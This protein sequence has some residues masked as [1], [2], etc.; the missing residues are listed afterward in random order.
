MNSSMNRAMNSTRD[1]T[2]DLPNTL[3]ACTFIVPTL[4]DLKSAISLVFRPLSSNKATSFSATVNSHF[5]NWLRTYS[6]KST[7]RADNCV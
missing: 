7:F 3:C 5:A 6:S 1:D 4:T 2:P